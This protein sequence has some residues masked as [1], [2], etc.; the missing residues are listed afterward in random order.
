MIRC[1]PIDG[2]APFE[3]EN[4]TLVAESDE[5]QDPVWTHAIWEPRVVVYVNGV[6]CKVELWRERAE[7][8][9]DELA[10]LRRKIALDAIDARLEYEHP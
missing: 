10:D 6:P 2:S 8:L 3:V 7:R 9:D 4:D 5:C 1:I